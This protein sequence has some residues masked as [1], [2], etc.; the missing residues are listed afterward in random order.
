MVGARI[1]GFLAGL[2]LVGLF[3]DR[4]LVDKHRLAPRRPPWI[5]RHERP[6]VPRW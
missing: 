5:G 3:R 1:G 4:E 2:A 6:S